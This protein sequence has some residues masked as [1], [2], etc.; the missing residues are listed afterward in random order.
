MNPI[1]IVNEEPM[2]EDDFG[3]VEEMPVSRPRLVRQTGYRHEEE[4][5]EEED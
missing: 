3:E 2:E 5:M 1:N 4:P